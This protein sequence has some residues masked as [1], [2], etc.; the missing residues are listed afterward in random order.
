MP[1]VAIALASPAFPGVIAMGIAAQCAIE[2]FR[3]RTTRRLA[4]RPVP[5]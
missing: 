5:A 4:P 3:V 1:V 2:W